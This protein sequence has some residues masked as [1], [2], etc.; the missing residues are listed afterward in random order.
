MYPK[1]NA[2]HRQHIVASRSVNG[3][4]PRTECCITVIM[5]GRCVPDS[6]HGMKIDS[7]CSQRIA[8]FGF[9]YAAGAVCWVARGSMSVKMQP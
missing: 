4:P 6:E 8:L 1:A 3:R 5:G 7:Y 9:N 2:V